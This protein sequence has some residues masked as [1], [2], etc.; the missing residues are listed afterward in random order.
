VASD[1]LALIGAVK[2]AGLE[3]FLINVADDDLVASHF[4]S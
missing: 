1:S 3:E 4:E 2:L